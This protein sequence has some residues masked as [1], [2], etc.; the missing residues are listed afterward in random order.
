MAEPEHLVLSIEK[1]KRLDRQDF[2][3]GVGDLD[4]IAR[5]SC[6]D[7]QSL[8]DCVNPSSAGAARG[9]CGPNPPFN[10]TGPNTALSAANS[11]Y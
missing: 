2:A 8:G 1:Q 9:I 5:A 6:Q 7:L 4:V 10:P 3:S 11:L